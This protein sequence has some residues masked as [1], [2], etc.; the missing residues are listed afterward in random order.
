MNW[1]DRVRISFLSGKDSKWER[2]IERL[3]ENRNSFACEG[4]TLRF[5]GRPELKYIP[6]RKNTPVRDNLHV[7]RKNARFLKKNELSLSKARD[8]YFE[9]NPRNL[10]TSL[11][12]HVS[13]TVSRVKLSWQQQKKISLGIISIIYS[14]Y[15]NHLCIWWWKLKKSLKHFRRRLTRTCNQKGFTNFYSRGIL[16][17]KQ[18]LRFLWLF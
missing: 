9:S 7:K 2:S 17:R 15:N 13:V 14:S 1:S 6:V 3:I 11:V 4:S 10:H 12:I 5:S 18:I 16:A 8:F